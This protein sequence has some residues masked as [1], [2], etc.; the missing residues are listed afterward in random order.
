MKIAFFRIAVFTALLVVSSSLSAVTV[1]AQKMTAEEVV[2]K[3]LDS[4]GTKDN[5]AKIK[6]QLIVTELKFSIKGSANAVN[7][8]ALILS[9]NAKNLWAMNIASNAYPQDRFGFNGKDTKVGYATPTSRS[10][11]GDFIFS[12][13]ELLKEGLLGG[14]L[15]SSWAL[16]NTD[17]RKSKLSYEGTKKI[18][19]KETVVLSYSPKSG[20]DLSMKMY[21]DAKNFQHV[22]T[23][24]SRTIGA[25]QGTTIDNSAGQGEDRYRLVEDFSDF[26]KM[27]DLTLPGT[28]KLSYSYSSSSATRTKGKENR[29]LEW[30]FKVVNYAYNRPQDA[31]AFDIDAK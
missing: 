13:T 22:R 4:I 31:N 15:S 10:I 19:G 9:E 25:V 8:K 20:S 3:H 1:S 24:Y 2:A 12:N 18:D 28:Y 11:I 30:E 27:G 17:T 23:E 16:L 29:E 14:T 7:G 5:R 26:T 21:F 6:N